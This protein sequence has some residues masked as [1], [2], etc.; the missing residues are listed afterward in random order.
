[1]EKSEMIKIAKKAID[2]KWDYEQLKYSDDLY[3]RE[4]LADDVWAFVEECGQMGM[5]AFLKQYPKSEGSK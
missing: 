3:G 1:M 5:V 4:Y 2:K